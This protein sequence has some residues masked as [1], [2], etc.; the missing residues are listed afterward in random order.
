MYIYIYIYLYMCVFQLHASNSS[1]HAIWLHFK[2]SQ[3][4][5]SCVQPLYHAS[6]VPAHCA[7]CEHICERPG[8]PRCSNPPWQNFSAHSLLTLRPWIKFVFSV[9]WATA[10]ALP[11]VASEWTK[12]PCLYLAVISLL[13][14]FWINAELDGSYFSMFRVSC[15]ILKSGRFQWAQGEWVAKWSEPRFGQ[16]SNDQSKLH[17]R[18]HANSANILPVYVQLCSLL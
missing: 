3:H 10:Y 2:S 1:S 15:L 16:I 9:L 17:Q 5:V 4:L 6:L 12:R 8:P 7:L 14:Q 11:I 18:E 13:S